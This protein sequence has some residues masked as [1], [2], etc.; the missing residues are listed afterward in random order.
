MPV[1]MPK[2]P[3]LLRALADVF[4]TLPV[5]PELGT[6]TSPLDLQIALWALAD[7]VEYAASADDDLEALEVRAE[8]AE[9]AL[10]ELIEDVEYAV[11]ALDNEDYPED[12]LGEVDDLRTAVGAARRALGSA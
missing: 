2:G 4:G 8:N 10:K 3:D 1:S 5:P 9:A 6:N 7:D 11:D 12:V